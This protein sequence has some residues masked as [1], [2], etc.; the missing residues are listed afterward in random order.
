M[1][2]LESIRVLGITSETLF[3][4]VADALRHGLPGEARA[5]LRVFDK[6]VEE[7]ERLTKQEAQ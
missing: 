6:A 3:A 1:T 2:V 5:Q 4:R 7:L